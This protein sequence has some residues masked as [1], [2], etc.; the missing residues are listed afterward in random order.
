M[1]SAVSYASQYLI[2]AVRICNAQYSRYLKFITSCLGSNCL[3]S[4]C[5]LC[6]INS[7][8]SVYLIVLC[9][10]IVYYILIIN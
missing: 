3:G 2:I 1:G 7:S 5:L 9:T 8:M 6:I 10:L 4:T